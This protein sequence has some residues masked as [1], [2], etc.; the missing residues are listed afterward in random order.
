MEFLLLET[1]ALTIVTLVMRYLVV[2]LGHV[3]LME[4]GVAVIPCVLEVSS[5]IHTVQLIFNW[6]HAHVHLF[7]YSI[8]I[9][10]YSLITCKYSKEQ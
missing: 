10:I 4:H 8:Y 5:F 3:R 6:T 9:S 7:N 2:V 1:C